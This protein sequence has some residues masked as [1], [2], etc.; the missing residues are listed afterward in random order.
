MADNRSLA[1]KQFDAKSKKVRSR[2]ALDA[3][4]ET[5]LE[6]LQ[7]I[8]TALVALDFVQLLGI[9]TSVVVAV[10]LASIVTFVGMGFAVACG[11]ACGAYILL[12]AINKKR[13]ELNLRAQIADLSDKK[14]AKIAEAITALKKLL[15][16]KNLALQDKDFFSARLANLESNKDIDNSLKE[17]NG[18]IKLRMFESDPENYRKPKGKK[19]GEVELLPI[20]NLNWLRHAIAFFSGVGFAM[21]ISASVLGAAMIPTALLLTTPVGWAL[22]ATIA[23]FAI[24]CGVAMTILDYRKRKSNEDMMDKLESKK[25]ELKETKSRLEKST[26]RIEDYASD[27]RKAGANKNTDLEVY[28]RL[29]EMP[30]SVSALTSTYTSK[31]NIEEESVGIR[32]RK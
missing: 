29:D 22:L 1:Q 27:L 8:S 19:S 14:T 23:V 11:L 24:G 15:A 17:I 7:A 6:F 4:L 2:R 10:T 20:R 5:A 25:S 32:K 21:G 13:E 12:D 28:E 3:A 18:L 9:T 30:L 16:M 26:V 31:N